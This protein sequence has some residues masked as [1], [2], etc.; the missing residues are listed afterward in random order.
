MNVADYLR[1]DT[2]HVFIHEISLPPFNLVS[3]TLWT[4]LRYSAFTFSIIHVYRIYPDIY[5]LLL[6]LSLS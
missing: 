6:Q 2:A 4:L 5:N 3:K 1:G